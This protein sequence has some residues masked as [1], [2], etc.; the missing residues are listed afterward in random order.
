MF[1]QYP[2][3]WNNRTP[4]SANIVR[5]RCASARMVVFGSLAANRV[6]TPLNPARRTL[7]HIA[8]VNAFM[9]TGRKQPLIPRR[10]TGSIVRIVKTLARNMHDAHRDHTQT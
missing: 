5:N 2:V 3:A 9:S 4:S 7:R 8:G 10:I 1:C 6:N